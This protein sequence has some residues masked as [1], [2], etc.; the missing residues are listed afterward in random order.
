[1]VDSAEPLSWE[2]SLSWCNFSKY[3]ITNCPNHSECI[4]DVIQTV[5][6]LGASAPPPLL[7]APFLITRHQMSSANNPVL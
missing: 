3:K 7:F 1:M 2:G 4:N 5:T 6:S